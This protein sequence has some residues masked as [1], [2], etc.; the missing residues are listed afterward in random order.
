MDICQSK[1]IHHK[2]TCSKYFGQRAKNALTTRFNSQNVIEGTY[3]I[4]QE[5]IEYSL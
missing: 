2:D 1:N 3:A 5:E 4:I